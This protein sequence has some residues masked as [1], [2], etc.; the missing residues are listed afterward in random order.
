MSELHTQSVFELVLA[1]PVLNQ[2]ERRTG[3]V[4]LWWRA[5]QQGHRLTQVYADDQLLAVTTHPRQREMLLTL[6]RA[7]P[8]RIELLAVDADELDAALTARPDLLGGWT[9]AVHDSADVALLRDESL[10]IGTRVTVRAGGALV[11]ESAMWDAAD[12]RG[13]H[14]ALFGLGGFGADDATGLGLGRGELGAGPLG[15]DTTLWRWR[16]RDIPPGADE[17][18]VQAHD[19]KGHPLT[20]ALSV[21]IALAPIDAAPPELN[22]T[23]DFTLTWTLPASQ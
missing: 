15:T 13:G 10:P 12:H 16:G 9:P 5:P 18:T 4:H 22:I 7:R 19:S 17:L 8:T 23:P 20:P 21:P 11:A 3:L 2:H 14:G 1:R 6:D